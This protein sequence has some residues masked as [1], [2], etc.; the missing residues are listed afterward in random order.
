M[1]HLKHILITPMIKFFRYRIF[2][3]IACVII[4]HNLQAEDV[5]V[6][7]V[8]VK[9]YSFMNDLANLIDKTSEITKQDIKKSGKDFYRL[10]ISPRNVKTND[11][12]S[13]FSFYPKGSYSIFIEYINELLSIATSYQYI[14]SI[15]NINFISCQDLTP[16]YTSCKRKRQVLN[17]KSYIL[18]SGV[19][20]HIS[21]KDGK[22][23]KAFFLN[24]EYD[25]PAYNTVYD[26]ISGETML[27]TEYIN[28][29]G[30][31]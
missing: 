30:Y 18:T 1:Y 13:P 26:L 10:E 29:Y 12:V 3:I 2:L 31:F 6:A 11:I 23:D 4:S 28:K 20:W 25:D 8:T 16:Y 22:I 14:L 9:D 17:F 27:E 19:Y 24:A 7:E 15:N 5:V 21:I